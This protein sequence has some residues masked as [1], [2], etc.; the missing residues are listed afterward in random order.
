V[1]CPMKVGRSRQVKK[2]P[3]MVAFLRLARMLHRWR[4]NARHLLFD[5]RINAA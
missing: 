4:S 1:R 2:P 5:A 3:A